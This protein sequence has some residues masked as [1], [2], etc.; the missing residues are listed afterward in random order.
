VKLND[1]FPVKRKSVALRPVI[2]SL[3]QVIVASTFWFVNPVIL[4][5]IRPV[6][7]VVSTTFIVLV[8][9]HV[10]FELSMYW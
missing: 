5:S 3:N 10:L 2:V 1:P 9:V 6:G 7:K 8:V 4:Y